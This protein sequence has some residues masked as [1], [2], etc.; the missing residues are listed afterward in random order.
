MGVL[1]ERWLLQGS[2][3]P[4]THRTRHWVSVGVSMGSGGHPL[5]H[6]IPWENRHRRDATGAG[7]GDAAPE[8]GMRLHSAS[9]GRNGS[10]L[11]LNL[12]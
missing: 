8:S 1:L 4:L 7:T 9:P 6:C 2:F 3:S 5:P 11:W 10:F 12:G